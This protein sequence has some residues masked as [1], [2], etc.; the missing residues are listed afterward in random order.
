MIRPECEYGYPMSQLKDILG[1]RFG[2]FEMFMV[3]Q[4]MLLCQADPVRKWVDDENAPGGAKLVEVGQSLC[5]KPH[6]L[7]AYPWD[8]HNFLYGGDVLD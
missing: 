3:G 1:D 8:V 7:V 4:T 2:D 6:G 5:H